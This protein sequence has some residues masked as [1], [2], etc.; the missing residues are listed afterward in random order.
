MKMFETTK[1]FI[2]LNLSPFTN[3]IVNLQMQGILIN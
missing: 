1:Y 3:Y 2:K